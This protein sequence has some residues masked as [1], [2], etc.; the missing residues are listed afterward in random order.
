M[1]FFSHC[2]WFNDLFPGLSSSPLF[3]VMDMYDAVC[4]ATELFGS[5]AVS[6]E[7][8]ITISL[9]A[10]KLVLEA[11]GDRSSLQQTRLPQDLGRM[12]TSNGQT[13]EW[14]RKRIEAAASLNAIVS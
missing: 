1:Y 4:K 3:A 8:C 6:D 7:E 11:T 14:Q 12:L 2:V 9:L 5:E 10:A 13:S